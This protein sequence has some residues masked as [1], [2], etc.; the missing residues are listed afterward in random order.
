M[1]FQPWKAKMTADPPRV[2]TA[3]LLF[4]NCLRLEARRARGYTS[5][6]A[7]MPEGLSSG[8]PRMHP[9]HS[10]LGC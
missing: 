4:Q 1:A 3:I 2:K 9:F 5:P 8:D 10:P 7:G 6:R